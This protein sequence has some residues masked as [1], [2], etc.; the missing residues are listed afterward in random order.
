M[1]GVPKAVSATPECSW[2]LRLHES[3]ST[4]VVGG[5]HGKPIPHAMARALGT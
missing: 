1:Q 4:R 5:M 2:D 3:P